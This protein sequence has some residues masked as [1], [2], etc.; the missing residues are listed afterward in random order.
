LFIE[1]AN[2]FGHSLWLDTHNGMG[3]LRVHSKTENKDTTIVAQAGLI[4]PIR[5]LTDDSAIYRIV[6]T[7]EI[8]DYVVGTTPGRQ[9]H[10]IADVVNT[11]GFS[12]GQ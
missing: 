11:Y 3:T 12:T 6:T 2:D 1:Q 9:M 5:W 7:G 4:Y 8:A 10:K